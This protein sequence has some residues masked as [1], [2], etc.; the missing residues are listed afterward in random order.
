MSGNVVDYEVEYRY[1][2]NGLILVLTGE[3]R[4]TLTDGSVKVSRIRETWKRL[5]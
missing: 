3:M 4:Q 2:L 1:S 5:E